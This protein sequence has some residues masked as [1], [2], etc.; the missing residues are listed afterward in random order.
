MCICIILPWWAYKFPHFYMAEYYDSIYRSPFL[1]LQHSG[2]RQMKMTSM[3]SPSPIEITEVMQ[4]LYTQGKRLKLIKV[5]CSVKAMISMLNMLKVSA[6]SFKRFISRLLKLSFS[7]YAPI[8]SD[9]CYAWFH[10]N[11]SMRGTRNK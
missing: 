1:H 9:G 10:L 7:V 11:A 2:T 3:H 4:Q 5:S 6:H 8:T